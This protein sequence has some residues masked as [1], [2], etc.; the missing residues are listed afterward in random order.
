MSGPDAPADD[1][2]GTGE[3]SGSLLPQD[4]DVVGQLIRA[5]LEHSGP[6]PR[7]ADLRD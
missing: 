2:D 4:G 7:P 1:P 6:L 5:S 3:T